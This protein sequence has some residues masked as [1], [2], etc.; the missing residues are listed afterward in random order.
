MLASC[1]RPSGPQGPVQ[2]GCQLGREDSGRK[3]GVRCQPWPLALE[4]LAGEI[5][6]LE[7]GEN[8]FCR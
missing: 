1:R 8:Q 2:A 5:E 3:G 4:A 6:E 7:A